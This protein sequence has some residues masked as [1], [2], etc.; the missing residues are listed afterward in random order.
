MQFCIVPWYKVRICK[1]ISY[2]KI[3]MDPLQ[4]QNGSVQRQDTND[5]DLLLPA[6]PDAAPVFLEV[7]P[8]DSLNES[9]SGFTIPPESKPSGDADHQDTNEPGSLPST[10]LPDGQGRGPP[11][12]PPRLQVPLINKQ[13]SLDL[14]EPAHKLNRSRTEVEDQV[15]IGCSFSAKT[16]FHF[17]HLLFKLTCVPTS[18]PLRYQ[19]NRYSTRQH[20]ESG[21]FLWSNNQ[22]R[23]NMR[24]FFILLCW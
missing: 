5:D 4:M 6:D 24:I 19:T 20:E 16:E 18:G 1:D 23:E 10:F 7:F 15:S 9:T 17:Y 3:V 11:P 12:V 22:V 21:D 13:F 2:E 8:D 14:S